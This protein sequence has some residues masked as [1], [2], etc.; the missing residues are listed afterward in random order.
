VDG[1]IVDIPHDV[2]H[3]LAIALIA[4]PQVVEDRRSDDGLGGHEGHE[5]FAGE[6]QIVQILRGIQHAKDPLDAKGRERIE[7]NLVPLERVRILLV[8]L[9]L[10]GRL[11]FLGIAPGPLFF[12]YPFVLL[13]QRLQVVVEVVG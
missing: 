12:P 8:L 13:E 3:D 7:R 6:D 5:E 11:L 4:L 1:A 2:G 9:A 10:T